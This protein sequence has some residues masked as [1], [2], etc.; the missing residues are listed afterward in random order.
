M[1]CNTRRTRVPL[2]KLLGQSSSLEI[3]KVPPASRMKACKWK[4]KVQTG[5]VEW[6]KRP[7]GVNS[8]HYPPY[9]EILYATFKLNRAETVDTTSSSCKTNTMCGYICLWTQLLKDFSCVGG[10]TC[11]RISQLDPDHPSLAEADWHFIAHLPFYSR[12]FRR[13]LRGLRSPWPVVRWSHT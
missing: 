11:C 7:W 8:I 9:L 3:G 13:L 4:G 2:N 1:H 12:L 10:T 6:V 5:N